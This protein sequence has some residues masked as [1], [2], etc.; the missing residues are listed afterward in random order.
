MLYNLIEG[1]SQFANDSCNAKLIIAAE[2]AQYKRKQSTK[3]KHSTGHV[4]Q[5][6]LI[7]NLVLIL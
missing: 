7:T 5:I 4:S 2:I 3:Y 1:L 6:Q